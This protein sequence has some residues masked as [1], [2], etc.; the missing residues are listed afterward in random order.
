MGTANITCSADITLTASYSN[1]SDTASVTYSPHLF[2]DECNSSSG[3]S[4]YSSTVRIGSTSN[5]GA[6][7]YNS[8]NNAYYISNSTTAD[9]WYGWV[10]PNTRGRDN[11]K[12]SV[13]AKINNTSA[14][15]QLLIGCA[16]NIA[17]SSSSGT[18]DL[19]RIRGDNKSDYLHN[20]GNEVSGSSSSTSVANSYVTVTFEKQ[21]T[22]IV[23]KVFNSSGTQI[24]SYTYSN[25]NS[26]TNPYFFV[27]V[28]TNK[29]ADNKY[30][31]LIQVDLI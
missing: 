2:F 27:L 24:R 21:G 13:K 30:I 10:I 11:I 16:D 3:L 15:N 23:G 28:N 29:A 12:I 25:A 18:Y 19:F 1:V 20:Y 31:Q 26:Y 8:Q 17:Q 22:T 14:Y 9:A 5:V 6:L 4:Q 7:S